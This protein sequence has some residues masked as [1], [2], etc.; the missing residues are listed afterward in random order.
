MTEEDINIFVDNNAD[1]NVTVNDETDINVTVNDESDIVFEFA[2]VIDASTIY[3]I[4]KFES[5]TMDSATLIAK[6]IEV[7]GTI[8]D[9]QSIRVFLDD[10]GIKAE[11][12]VDYSVSAN[13]IFWSGYNFQILLEVGDKLKI[14]YV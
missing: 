8:T 6:Y 10:V 12:G 9:N 14:F 1:I 4:D 5:F 2:D 3:R 13:Q 11:Q 7:A